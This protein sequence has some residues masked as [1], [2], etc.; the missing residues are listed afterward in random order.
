VPD[1]IEW[2]MKTGV[3]PTQFGIKMG[4]IRATNILFVCVIPRRTLD[5]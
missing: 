2:W 3:I 5:P 1:I 4:V